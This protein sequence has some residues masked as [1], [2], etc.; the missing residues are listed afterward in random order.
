MRL[1]VYVVMCLS[2]VNTHAEL[3]KAK[4]DLEAMKKQAESTSAEYDRLAEEHQKL[5]VCRYLN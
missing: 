2:H 4:T 5:L 1:S 3:K